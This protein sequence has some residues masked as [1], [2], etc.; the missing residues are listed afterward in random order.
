MNSGDFYI[1]GFQLAVYFNTSVIV[2]VKDGESA[3]DDWDESAVYT[4]GSP[5]N[6]VLLSSVATDSTVT[7]GFVHASAT[8]GASQQKVA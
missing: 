2:A 6:A 1:T 5:S 4:Y 3:G 7:G 8:Y